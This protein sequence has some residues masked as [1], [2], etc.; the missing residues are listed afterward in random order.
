ME[1]ESSWIL[2]GELRLG[3]ILGCIA[4]LKGEAKNS[5]TFA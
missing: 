2:N 5:F 3:F 1:A 4:Y